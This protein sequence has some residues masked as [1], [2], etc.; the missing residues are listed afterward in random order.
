MPGR[1]ELKTLEAHVCT[2]FK[3]MR[4]YTVKPKWMSFS[5]PRFPGDLESVPETA[6]LACGGCGEDVLGTWL[7]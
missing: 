5:V 6:E 2:S 3:K 1:F 7:R 4:P